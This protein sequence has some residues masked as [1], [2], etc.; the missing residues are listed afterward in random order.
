[1]LTIKERYLTEIKLAERMDVRRAAEATQQPA[2]MSGRPECRLNPAERAGKQ[3]LET[4]RP[5]RGQRRQPKQP[6]ESPG[7]GSPERLPR[8][9]ARILRVGLH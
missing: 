3:F 6:E 2:W 9:R 5:V 4:L 1:M 8:W 7:I